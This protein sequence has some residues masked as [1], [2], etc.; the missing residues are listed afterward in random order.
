MPTL[1]IY[2]FIT[3]GGTLA[4]D[5][6]GPP[7]GSLLIE[8]YAMLTAVAT[9]FA[10]IEALDIHVIQDSRVEL[11]LPAIVT[12]TSVDDA[13]SES[14]G[15][16]EA[17]RSNDLVL[18]I[19]PEIG[20]HLVRRTARAEQLGANLI[21]PPSSF[22]QMAADKLRLAEHFKTHGVPTPRLGADTFPCI[23]KPRDGCGSVGVKLIPAAEYLPK[24]SGDSIVQAYVPG[25]ACS[26][27]VL[28]GGRTPIALPPM[29]QWIDP[30]DGF[31]FKGGR[32]MTNPR[33][34]DRAQSLA[35]SAI[36]SMPPARG[37]VG[38]DMVLGHSQDGANDAV[39]EVN[40]RVTTSY[41][42]LR[43]M[44]LGNLGQAL[45]DA[46]TGRDVELKFQSK[47]IE[48]GPDGSVRQLR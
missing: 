8:G 46:A 39:I 32:S 21:C 13:R 31:A 9:D 45:Q 2:E 35:L 1:F 18:I 48:F 12:C 15:F 3:G 10:A 25:I 41:V 29:Q 37:Y 23:V 4:D 33:L 34:I 24:S 22:V 40:P 20:G 19:A 14:S 27:A 44:L 5:S 11:E 7:A 16:D 47:P 28:C 42:G 43:H 17:V 38:V 6:I 26:V 30:Q 36:N